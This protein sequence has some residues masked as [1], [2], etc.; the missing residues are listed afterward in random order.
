MNINLGIMI[1]EKLNSLE[2][3]LFYEYYPNI[4][5]CSKYIEFHHCG[6]CTND[7]D[8]YCTKIIE[9]NNYNFYYIE[10][11]TDTPKN[12]RTFFWSNNY[13]GYNNLI[14]IDDEWFKCNERCEACLDKKKTRN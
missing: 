3:C 14:F 10:N 8:N 6:N 12:N 1:L 4:K 9:G 5:K 13:E 7:N 11:Q 2:E